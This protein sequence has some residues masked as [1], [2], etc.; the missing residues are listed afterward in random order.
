[1]IELQTGKKE[2]KLNN[3]SKLNEGIVHMC[4]LVDNV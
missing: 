2:D 1:M 3:W 4:F